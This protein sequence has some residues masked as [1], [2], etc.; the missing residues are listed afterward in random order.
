MNSAS[1]VNWRI[2]WMRTRRALVS[3][4]TVASKSAQSTCSI[5]LA[6]FALSCLPR[7]VSWPMLSLLPLGT[8]RREAWSL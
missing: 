4:S 3:S 2:P 7:R 5:M 6:M 8:S 1:E